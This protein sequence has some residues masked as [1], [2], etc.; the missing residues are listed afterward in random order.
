M[1]RRRVL[2]FALTGAVMLSVLFLVWILKTNLGNEIRALAHAPESVVPLAEEL[3]DRIVEQPEAGAT[4]SFGI[5]AVLLSQLEAVPGVIFCRDPRQHP[6]EVVVVVTPTYTVVV[7]DE[8]PAVVHA[9]DPES[10]D[11]HPAE[12][13]REGP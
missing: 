13:D 12:P 4:A 5:D 2:G 10:M 1:T 7:A 3:R 8:G 9:L 11:W 6:E